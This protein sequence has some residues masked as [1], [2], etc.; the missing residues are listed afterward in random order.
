[1]QV[2]GELRR[3]WFTDAHFDL[4]VWLTADNGVEA[5][6]LCYDVAHCGHALTWSRLSGYSHDR[7]DDGESSP[8]RNRT[9]VL[10]ADGQFPADEILRRFEESCEQVDASIRS[11][12]AEKIRA[13]TAGHRGPPGR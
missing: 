12:V 1:M 11:V 3:R 2:P 13:Y 4:I 5:F 8:M 10:V 6:Q 7:I 9:P